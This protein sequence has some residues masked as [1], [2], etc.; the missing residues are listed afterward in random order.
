[1]KTYEG[2][3]TTLETVNSE[4]DV[5][6]S[7]DGNLSFANHIQNQVNKA[8]QIVG[9][10]RR[11]FVHLDNRT[12][13]LLFKAL[14]RPHL[15]YVHSVWTPYKKA[16]ITSIK[17]VQKRATKMLP[18]LENLTYEERLIALKLP[19]LRFRRLRGDMIET[20]KIL[21]GIYDRKVTE[22]LFELNQESKSGGHT[23]KIRKQR[24]RL[25]VRKFFFT[26][27]IVDIWNNLKEEIFSA[28][29]LNTFKNKQ[30][31]TNR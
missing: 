22:D 20:F 6:V 28:K 31:E 13:H 29:N 7:I 27:R 12:F 19:T 14:V 11:S 10:T 1:M 24:R 26:N 25:N 30:D 17:N 3:L 21:K 18:T 4:K 23:L 16:D 8:N 15:E 2:G 9:L 5:A